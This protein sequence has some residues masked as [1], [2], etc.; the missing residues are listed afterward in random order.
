MPPVAS[1]RS[2]VAAAGRT[3]S[4]T[5]HRLPASMRLVAGAGALG[6][7]VFVGVENMDVLEAP[8]LGSPIAEIRATYADDN[9]LAVV[10]AFCGALALLSYVVFVPALVGMLRPLEP[11]GESWS[12]VALVGGIAGPAV[13]AAGATATAVL[14]YTATAGLSDELTRTL[15]DFHVLAQLIAGV[16]VSVFLVAVGIAGLRTAALP[17]WLAWFALPIGALAALLP[18]AAL[19]ADDALELAATLVYA[20]QTLWVFAAGLWLLL[21]HGQGFATQL[22]QGAFLV[23]VLAAGL[24]GIALLAV[25]AKA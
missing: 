2:N 11:R 8:T 15:F 13:A 22:R 18:I 4:S 6:Y 14:T 5:A 23:L 19:T 25:P 24:V 7:V 21:A 1:V 12:L 10:T 16:F 3:M 17:R 20:G 9:A